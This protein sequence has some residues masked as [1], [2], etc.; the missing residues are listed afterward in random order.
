MSNGRAQ[1]RRGPGFRRKIRTLPLRFEDSELEG[2]TI[3]VKSLDTGEFLSLAALVEMDFETLG[4]EEVAAVEKMFTLFSSKMVEWNMTDED[5]TPLPPTK[6]SL[7]SLEL[8][9][10]I[11]MITGY[12]NAVAGVSGPLERPSTSGEQSLEESIPMDVS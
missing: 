4:P 2:L 3:E 9:D 8:F 5:D 6:E 12:M 11:E 10:V 7:Y 1:K